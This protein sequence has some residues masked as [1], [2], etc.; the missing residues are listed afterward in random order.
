MTTTIKVR[1]AG[2]LHDGW[3]SAHR[4]APGV[5]GW[6]RKAAYAV[7]YT[8]L[9]AS[10][11]RIAVCTFHVP[12]GRGDI[13]SGFAPSGVPGIPIELYVILLSVASELLAFTAVGLVSSWGEVFPRWIPVLRGR[14]VPTLAAVVP[15]ALGAA[16]L[17]LL[18]TWVAVSFSLGMRINGR[19]LAS[20]SVLS[21][22]DW[23][24]LVAVIAYA[25]LLLWGPLLGAVTISYWKRRRSCAGILWRLVAGGEPA[26]RA[27]PVA[28]WDQ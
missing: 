28:E 11:W 15:A 6:A 8:V 9:P 10:L 4:P 7:P 26:D 24:G 21:F 18:W 27:A 20:D 17:T 25:P 5:P 3:A 16:A 2:R 12:I 14:R 19:P 13:G 23:K 1:P 22:G